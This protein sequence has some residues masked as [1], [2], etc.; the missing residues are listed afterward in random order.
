MKIIEFRDKKYPDFITTG[1]HARFIMPV[2]KEVLGEGVGVDVGC[3]Y[4]EWSYPGSVCVD[5]SFGDG[6]EA[7]NLPLAGQLDYI[8][9]SHCLEHIPDWEY[10][11]EYWLTAL[12]PGGKVFLYL[13]HTDNEY[14]DARFMPT[15]RHV[16]NLTP[17]AVA[18]VMERVGFVNV[19]KSERDAAYSFCVYGETLCPA[20][21]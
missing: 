18:Y 11:L 2:A 17:D 3:K 10:V 16:N 19:F 20:S 1:N 7:L 12:K 13:P 15:R 4:P 14:W 8:F 9:S 21:L 5:L 6:F